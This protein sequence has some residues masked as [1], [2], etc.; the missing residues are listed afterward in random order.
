A[1]EVKNNADS[2]IYQTEKALK[3]LEDKISEDEKSNV[4][5]KLEALK[6][7]VEGDDIEDMK[8][9][10]EELTEAFYSISEKLYQQTEGQGQTTASDSDDE[11]V[12]DA[13]YEVV[14][15]D[16]DE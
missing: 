1:I 11:D 4:E 3:D 16:E 2:M 10:T 6:T 13:D 9:K 7:S 14:D 12:V 5:S 8:K 15:D